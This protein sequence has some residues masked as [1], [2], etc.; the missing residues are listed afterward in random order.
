MILQ[1]PELLLPVLLLLFPWT[2][3]AEMI[4]GTV[5]R[6]DRDRA[7]I[8]L[9][10]AGDREITIHSA[11]PLP[12]R[13]RAGR[14]IRAWGEYSTDKVFQ[15]TDIRGP[16]RHHGHDPTGVRQRLHRGW[17]C[18]GSAPAATGRIGDAP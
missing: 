8:D 7:K 4:S 1:R 16:G 11:A 12:R 5:L 15:A 2:A 18:A 13:L 10:L 3:G 6:V 9:L 17:N 14:T